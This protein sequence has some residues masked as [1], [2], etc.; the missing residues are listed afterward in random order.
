MNDQRQHG[1]GDGSDNRHDDEPARGSMGPAFPLRTVRA[2]FR[3][4][5]PVAISVGAYGVALGL[6]AAAAPRGG[7]SL[8]ELLIMDVLVLAGSAQIVAV[9]LW[10]QPVP[11]ASIVLA[12]LVVNLRYLLICATLHPLFEKRPLIVKLAGIHLVADE[13]WAITMAEHRRRPQVPGFLLGGGLAILVFWIAGCAVGFLVGGNLPPPERLGLDF[14]F[15]AAFIA[16]ALSFWRGKADLLPWIAAG[17]AAALTH[18]LAGGTWHIL[19]GAIVGSL[20]A[21][22]HPAPTGTETGRDRAT[23]ASDPHRAAA[24]AG[25]DR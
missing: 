15:T 12:T 21:A 16:L 10:S 24:A 13:N 2:G 8:A 23:E 7:I 4:T 1:H 17:T 5:T 9:G 20:V 25:G 14:A 18:A 11:V 22:L 3:A 6:V 19:A